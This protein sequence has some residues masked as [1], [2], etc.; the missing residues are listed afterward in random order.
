[1][2]KL[3]R[4]GAHVVASEPR[5]PAFFELAKK[6]KPYAIAIDF[7][8]APSH[9]LETADYLAKAKETRDAAIYLLRVPADRMDIVTK[10]LPQAAI[11]TDQELAARVTDAEREAQE[12][13]RQKKEAA[14]AA[15]KNARAR[16]AGE[17]PPAAG[18]P[19]GSA[20]Q[21]KPAPVKSPAKPKKPQARLEKKAAA[22]KKK[23]AASGKTV[24]RPSRKR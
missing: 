24:P 22:P 5:W 8:Q 21:A 6:E 16:V 19:A 1:M 4:T 2:Q 23:K 17:K 11:V 14:A 18:K 3:A 15:R 7:S 13:A 10:R 12:R 9:S 20:R